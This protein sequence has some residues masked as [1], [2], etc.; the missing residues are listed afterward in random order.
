MNKTKPTDFAYELYRFFSSYLPYERNY[1]NNTISSYNVSWNLFRLYCADIVG[2]DMSQLC[3]DQITVELIQS[4]LEWLGTERGNSIAT[5]N[6]RLTAIKVFMKYVSRRN[7]KFVFQ[8]QR[9]QAIEYGKTSEPNIPYLSFETI[10][11]VLQQP[12]IKTK[13]GLRDRLLLELLYESAVRV[14]EL[15]DIQIKDVRFENPATVRICGKGNKQRVIPIHSKLA[16]RLN[17]YAKEFGLLDTLSNSV[18]LFT[19]INGEKL[20]RSGIAYIVK[21]YCDIAAKTTGIVFP[22]KVSPHVFRHSKAVHLLQAG[23]NMVYIRDILGHEDISTTQIYARAD[24]ETKRAAI[25]TAFVDTPLDE[26]VTEL[27]PWKKDDQLMS[28]LMGL[29]VTQ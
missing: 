14:Q 20:T 8:A 24:T 2:I 5:K 25:E 1:S 17:R 28:W 21:Y 13:K 16:S 9:I 11:C 29:G 10:Q 23:V 18:P 27:A 15:A 3:I 12:N 4:F 19:N 22:S 26:D 6:Q 7:S